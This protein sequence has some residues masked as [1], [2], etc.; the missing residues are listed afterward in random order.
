M[1]NVNDF[2]PW[3]QGFRCKE[4]FKVVVDM[5]DLRSWP[6]YSKCYEQLKV[7]DDMSYYGSLARGYAMTN[8]RL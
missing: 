5:N 1:D 3:A 4:Q 7:M 6:Q 2:K 8:S